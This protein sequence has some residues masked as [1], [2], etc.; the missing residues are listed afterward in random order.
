[1]RR[2]LPVLLACAVL[3]LAAGCGAEDSVKNT[4]DPVA[5]AA[6]KTADAGSVQLSM[7]G[8]VSAAGQEV[9]IDATGAFDLKA[10][11]GHMQLTTNVPG[12]GDVRIDEL[13]DGLV[14]YMRSDALT[15]SLPGGKH[16]IKI[17]LQ[18]LGKKSGIDLGQ[19]QQL[20]GGTDPTQFLTYLKKAGKVEKVGSE[21]I[22][23]TATT[24]YHATID[25]DK[26]ADSSG[27]AGASV[28]QLEQLTGNKTLPTDIWIDGQGRARRQKIEYSAKQPVPT[29]V[30]F[31]IDYEKFGVPVD[32]NKPDAGD[33]VDFAAL[34]GGG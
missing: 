34:V 13:L 12:K 17:D 21:D 22:N 1:M 9:P 4:V 33:T 6:T 5:Q 24:H 32:V 26:L 20:G 11:R 14:I 3:P 10:K 18:A 16:W 30:S 29:S 25:L 2:L 19:L 31:T 28:R 23:G 7:T 27:D 15:S 8:K